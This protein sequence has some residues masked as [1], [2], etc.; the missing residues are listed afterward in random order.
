M[1]INAAAVNSK[2]LFFFPFF[3][4]WNKEVYYSQDRKK[5][6]TACFKTLQILFFF[7]GYLLFILLS[8]FL[9]LKEDPLTFHVIMV[10]W[11]WT[12][13]AFP[14]LGKSSSVL[15]FKII[16]L[17]CW[18]ILVVGPYFLSLWIFCCNP[19]WPVKFLFQNQWQ[20]YGS[21]LVG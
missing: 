5:K 11:W 20:S 15:Q 12:P 18:V 13:L 9:L 14:C 4:H 7:N 17:L 6:Y 19:F 16:V 1:S 10:W 21:S 2:I 8:F 3:L